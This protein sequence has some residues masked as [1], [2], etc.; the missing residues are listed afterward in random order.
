MQKRLPILLILTACVFTSF[1]QD[2]VGINTTMPDPSAALH[3]EA[4]DKGMLIPRLTTQQRQMI[5]NAATGLLVFD[6]DTGGFWFYNGSAW[7]DL[8]DPNGDDVWQ[9]NGDNIYYG[10]GKVGIGTNNPSDALTIFGTLATLT[11]NNDNELIKFFSIPSWQGDRGTIINGLFDGRGFGSQL[12]FQGV[13]DAGYVDIG[14]NFEGDFVVEGTNDVPLFTVEQGGDVKTE[15][16]IKN[17]T[18]PVENQDAATKVYIDLKESDLLDSLAQEVLDRIAGDLAEKMARET[19]DQT[20]QDLLDQAIQD[21]IAGD[22]TEHQHHL[23]G[24]HWEKIVNNIY[25]SLGNVGIGTNTPLAQAAGQTVLEIEGN[26]PQITLDDNAGNAQN[27]FRIINGGFTANFQN[28]GTNEDIMVLELTTKDVGIGT[29]DP[30]EK[31][32]VVGNVKADAFL[33]DGSSLTGILPANP[34]AGDIVYYD[35]GA[36]MKIPAGSEGQVLTVSNG[37]PV[38]GGGGQLDSLFQVNLPG[39]EILYVHPTDNSTDLEWGG[40]GTDISELSNIMNIDDAMM[41]LNGEA[42][43]QVIITELGAGTYAAK[44]CIDLVAFGFDDWYLPSAEELNLIYEQLGPGGNNNFENDYYWT[45]TEFN[46][47]LTWIQI[48]GDGTR[49]LDDK[50]SLYH[51]RCVR[52]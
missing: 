29:V 28:A 6:T 46:E 2:N 12:R 33:G 42:N 22:A 19:A 34:Q 27:D 45:S 17:V 36:W 5:S 8:S 15:G 7:V 25:Y 30:Q 1:A 14:N 16:R 18:D 52:R 20:I 40:Y 35:G 39:G 21:R 4:D 24:D 48:F 10:Q 41:D 23:D 31:L 26:V 3:V 11:Y 13:P 43:T 44:L 49:G 50:R 9:K 38:W 47:A 51:C 37:I 32:E